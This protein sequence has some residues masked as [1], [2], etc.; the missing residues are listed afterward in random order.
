MEAVV[1]AACN[2]YTPDVCLALSLSCEDETADMT[3]DQDPYIPTVATESYKDCLLGSSLSPDQPKVLQDLLIQNANDSSDLPGRTNTVQC[4]VTLRDGK[5]PIRHSNELPHALEPQFQ[6]ELLRSLELGIVV[7]SSS[8]YCSPLI[9]VRKKDG[10]HRFCLDCHQLNLITVP[11]LE[12]IADQAHIFTKLLSAKYLSKLDLAFGFWQIGLSE[13][14]R[15]MTAFW[16]RSGHFQ[17]CVMPFGMT[18]APA[19]FSRLMREVIRDLHNTE[20]YLLF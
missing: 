13:A 20:A 5:G 8:P 10:T 18:N 7:P 2:S 14:K 1:E 6:Q 3:P 11:D 19:C 17:F 15:P 16:T 12:P 9:A 4:H